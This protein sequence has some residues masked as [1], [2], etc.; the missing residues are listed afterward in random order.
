MMRVGYGGVLVPTAAP[1]FHHRPGDD[2]SKAGLGPPAKYGIQ[3]GHH[4]CEKVD[5][6]AL[7]LEEEAI[8]ARRAS[9]LENRHS[10]LVDVANRNAKDAGT[11]LTSHNME[12]FYGPASAPKDHWGNLSMTP[13]WNGQGDV[14]PALA[15]AVGTEKS[16]V[17]PPTWKGALPYG[18]GSRARWSISSGGPDEPPFIRPNSRELTTAFREKTGMLGTR[19]D[20]EDF[21]AR[22]AMRYETI[23]NAHGFDGLFA[24][25][26]DLYAAYKN[27]DAAAFRAALS[28]A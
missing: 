28:G 17:A 20:L 5:G 23:G 7:T 10:A 9:L 14:P 27:G 11:V 19:S 22:E 2:G 12:L 13:Q 24:N 3:Y 16:H 1:P 15:A 6:S 8:A 18:P 21:L 26:P 4:G 25:K